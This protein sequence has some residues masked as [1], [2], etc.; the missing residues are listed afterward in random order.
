MAAERFARSQ[1]DMSDTFGT[2][3][4]DS[5]S[6]GLRR[7]A[8][9]LAPVLLLVAVAQLLDLVTFA[10]AVER[11]G[12]QG[13]LGPLGLVYELAGYWAVAAVKVVTIALVMLA[14]VGYSWKRAV[15]PWRIGLFTAGIGA[16]GAATNVAALL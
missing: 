2:A 12:I 7:T 11:W 10:F 4:D 14:M 6:S 5:R 15:T 3:D 1:F 9:E 8:A 13:E 16:F